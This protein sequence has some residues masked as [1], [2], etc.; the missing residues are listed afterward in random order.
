[1]KETTPLRGLQV[2]R[3]GYHL[4]CSANYDRTHNYEP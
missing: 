1:M 4:E 3:P 2:D